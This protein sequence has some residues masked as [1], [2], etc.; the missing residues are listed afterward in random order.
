[1]L[2]PKTLEQPLA[3]WSYSKRSLLVNAVPLPSVYI[4]NLT[5]AYN[6]CSYCMGPHHHPLSPRLPWQLLDWYPCFCLVPLYIAFI[7]STAARV[8][9]IHKGALNPL[10]I[11]HFTQSKSLSLLPPEWLLHIWLLLLSPCPCS[12]LSGY[13]DPPVFPALR[14]LRLLSPLCLERCYPDR[15]SLFQLFAQMSPSE[16]SF[17]WLPI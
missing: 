5:I 8:I 7:L 14:P 4:Q 3:P 11:P 16:C 10:V 9:V 13:T 12:L 17:P 2:K 1:M 6:F 15:H